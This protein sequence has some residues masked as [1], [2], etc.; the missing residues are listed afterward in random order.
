M[1][2]ASNQMGKINRIYLSK[3]IGLMPFN[4]ELK[5]RAR[6]DEED[7]KKNTRRNTLICILTTRFF[8]SHS[9]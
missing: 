7:E 5:S 9:Q 2:N 8:V 4:N 3:R 6:F 1:K